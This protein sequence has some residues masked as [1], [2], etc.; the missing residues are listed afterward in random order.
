[1]TTGSTLVF[2]VYERFPSRI[3]PFYAPDPVRDDFKERLLH[4]RRKGIK[5]CGELKVSLNWE[6][7]E[8]T[9][10]LNCLRQLEMPLVFH[11]EE[12]RECFE[13]GVNATRREHL[14]AKL[15]ESTK[16]HGQPKETMALISRFFPP[17]KARR[18]KMFC[19]FPGYLMDF[20]SLERRL[21]EYPDVTFI[22]HGPLFWKGIKLHW[23]RSQAT[24]PRTK[25]KEPGITCRLLAEYRNLY[26]DI[27]GPSGFNALNRDKKF[28]KRFLSEH[29]DKILYG[30]DNYELGLQ[31]LLNSLGLARRTYSK[32]YGENALKIV[33]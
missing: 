29:E 15:F 7:D 14:L 13:P 5:G 27:S 12:A 20:A 25:V 8:I 28:T 6:S 18:D 30:T 26:A 2:E 32:I 10:L 1:M 24:Y 3:I 4:W 17:L 19:M 31:N 16:L 9:R 21:I 22:G 11:M 33:P 23:E